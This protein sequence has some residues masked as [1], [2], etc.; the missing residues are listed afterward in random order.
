M[1]RVPLGE[2]LTLDLDVPSIGRVRVRPLF[3]LRLMKAEAAASAAARATSAE[4]R[5]LERASLLTREV[6][7]RACTLVVD[8]R[9]TPIAPADLADAPHDITASLWRAYVTASTQAS[10]EV[11]TAA[12][13][14]SEAYDLERFRARHARDLVAFYGLRAALDATVEQLLYFHA[15]IATEKS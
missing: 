3:G 8:G 15:L 12:I 2:L 11:D 9:E 13:R 4:E 6:L 7:A 5:E 14:A 10:G 1:P